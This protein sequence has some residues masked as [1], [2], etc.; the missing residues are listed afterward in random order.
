MLN[1]TAYPADNSNKLLCERYIIAAGLA[2]VGVWDWFFKQEEIYWDDLMMETYGL[3]KNTPLS[4][5]MWAAMLVPEDYEASVNAILRLQK[6]IDKESTFLFRIKRPDGQ[7]RLMQSTAKGIADENGIVYRLVGIHIDITEQ[8]ETQDKLM[9]SESQFRGAF[10]NSAIGMALVSPEGKWLAVNKSV[11][12]MLGYSENEFRSITFQ[13]ITHPEDLEADLEKVRQLLAGEIQGYS[14]EKRYIHKNGN[15]IWGILNVTL[16]RDADGTARHFVS[17]IKDITSRINSEQKLKKF[18]RELTGILNSGTQVSIISTNMYGVIE[19]FSKG[20]EILLGYMAEEMEGKQTPAIFHD[21]KEIET[22]GK[23]L[24]ALLNKEITGFDV[25]VE[26]ARMGQ[27]ESREWTYIRKDGTRFPVQLVVSPITDDNENIIGF[28]GIATDITQRKQ[29]EETAL[30]YAE[31]EAKNKETEQFTYIASHDLQEPLRTVHSYVQ[32]LQEEYAGSLDEEAQLYLRFISQSVNRMI[33][34]VKELLYYSLI[35]KERR[36]ETVDC[37]EIV[38]DVLHDM[39]VRVRETGAI[40]STQHLPVIKGYNAE[41][42][43][44][45]LNLISNALK[46]H[47]PGSTPVIEIVSTKKKGKWQFSVKD[48]GIGISEKDADKI[49]ILFKRLHHVRDYPGTGIGLAQCKKIVE[50]H[51]GNIWVES[52]PGSGSTFHF[53]ISG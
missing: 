26:F 49:F 40:I 14:M 11:C 22:R 17:Q 36:L 7:I 19:H 51:S 20:A 45:F 15:V 53:T 31:L 28:L 16:V 34:Q 23:E 9:M 42:K 27:F 1:N 25:F 30:K 24:S 47:K 6:G 50:M 48:N 2:R 39:E 29:A 3:Q 38:R 43:R 37:N 12:D 33:I 35:G 41:L 52:E 5:Q 8:K 18:N 46:F 32:I 10:E 13:D 4:Y 21:K 44:L